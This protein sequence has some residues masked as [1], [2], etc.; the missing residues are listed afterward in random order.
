[1]D[2]HDATARSVP[3]RAGES[4]RSWNRQCLELG[5]ANDL[6]VARRRVSAV[7]RATQLDAIA[8]DGAD[9]HEFEAARATEVGDRTV[10]GRIGGRNR[11]ALGLIQQDQI[12]GS[13]RPSPVTVKLEA[14]STVKLVA[15]MLTFDAKAA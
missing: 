4:G 8:V 13:Q 6:R 10:A 9:F 7:Q 3:G 14:S 11:G 1:M 12:A 2:G 5:Y 15:P